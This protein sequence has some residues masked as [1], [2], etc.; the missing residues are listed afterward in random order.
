MHCSQAKSTAVVKAAMSKMQD[1]VT[2]SINVAADRVL[3]NANRNTAQVLSGIQETRK[4]LSHQMDGITDQIGGLTHEVRDMANDLAHNVQ[5]TEKRIMNRIERTSQQLQSDIE[6]VERQVVART[7]LIMDKVDAG[8]ETLGNQI[9]D[10]ER[11]FDTEVAALQAQ[12]TVMT[13]ILV[14]NTMRMDELHEAIGGSLDLAEEHQ[15]ELFTMQ[16]AQA[17]MGVRTAFSTAF[18]LSQGVQKARAAY[19]RAV[20]NYTWCTIPWPRVMEAKWRLRQAEN[21]LSQ[22]QLLEAFKKARDSFTLVAKVLSTGRVLRRVVEKAV[23]EIPPEEVRGNSTDFCRSYL[24]PAGLAH[25]ASVL[26]RS[27]TKAVTFVTEQLLVLVRRG[28]SLSVGD[29]PW[30]T[31]H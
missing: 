8:I 4:A 6:N 26:R 22:E 12:Q 13:D 1:S 9:R 16:M 3:M 19:G 25:A 23:L 28:L 14:A 31:S 18:D 5:E 30:T 11:K 2:S 20:A 7:D 10:F 27:V 24:A 15:L 17:M 29:V 21:L